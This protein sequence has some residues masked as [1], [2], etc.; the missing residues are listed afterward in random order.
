MN[1]KPIE[2][3]PRDGTWFRAKTSEGVERVVHFEDYWDRFPIFSGMAP[4]PTEPI[5]WCELE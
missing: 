4:W 1:W 5:Y 2:T 3:A